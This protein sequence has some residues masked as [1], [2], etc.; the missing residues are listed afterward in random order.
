MSLKKF[1]D[2]IQ[3]TEAN[4]LEK[5]QKVFK[6]GEYRK[7]SDKYAKIVQSMMEFLRMYKDD[8][9]ISRIEDD[10]DHFQKVTNLTNDEIVDFIKNN[11]KTNLISFDVEIHGNKIVFSNLNNS[12]KKR[13][14]WEENTNERLTDKYV[15]TWLGDLEK[16][17][18]F[19]N[20]VIHKTKDDFIIYEYI[21]D[22][23]GKTYRYELCTPKNQRIGE[24]DTFTEVAEGL[25]EYL[26][27]FVQKL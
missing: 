23:T 14:V 27:Q 13:Y 20:G 17:G 25:V 3:P 8:L 15:K 21:D 10:L 22:D 19:A 9:K 5:T 24:Y 4:Q 7:N 12:M 18:K 26:N 1:E 6:Y 11:D 2:Y 16:T